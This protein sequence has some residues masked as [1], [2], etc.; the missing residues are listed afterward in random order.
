MR[1]GK[2]K[3][4]DR[5]LLLGDFVCS[6]KICLKFSNNKYSDNIYYRLHNGYRK[7]NKMFYFHKLV[8][9]RVNVLCEF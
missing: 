7:S 5:L 1:D 8:I 9:I 4:F 6:I 2:Q 3:M